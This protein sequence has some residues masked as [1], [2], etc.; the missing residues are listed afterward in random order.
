LPSDLKEGNLVT[1]LPDGKDLHL[2]IR[3]EDAENTRKLDGIDGISTLNK[4][5]NIRDIFKKHFGP[6]QP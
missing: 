3:R 2:R 4:P 6:R 5:E 1:K